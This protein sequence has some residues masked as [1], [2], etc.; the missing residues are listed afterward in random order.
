MIEVIGIEGSHE[1]KVAYA[2]KAAFVAQWPGLE[3]SPASEEHVKIAANAKLAGYQ[4]SDVDIVI[5]AVFHRARHFVVRRPIKDKE[6]RSVSGVKVRVQNL[7]CAIEVKAQ[8]GD[9]VSISGDEVNVRYK[10]KWKSATDQNVK[11]VHAL[12]N[13]FEDQY[14]DCWVYRCVYL[15]GIDSLPRVNGLARPEAGAVAS[16]AP[17]GEL[18]AAISGVNGLG[19]WGAEYVV[20]SA[21]NE[22]LKKVLEAPV[23][24][25][26][27][28]SRLDRIR[29]DR[30]SS[31]RKEAERLAALLGKQRVHIRGH[32]GT[33]KTMLMLQAAHLA[34]ELH[35]RRCLVLTYNHALAGDIKR[36]LTLLAVPSSDEG[37]GIE[38]KTAMSFVSTWLARLGLGTERGA[39]FDEYEK[40]CNECIGLLEGG[41]I[42]PADVHKTID[43]DPDALRFDAIIVDEAQDWPQPEAA[44]LTSLYGGNRV[45]V[46]DGREQ[47]LR[48]KA[49]DW[50]R[51]LPAGEVGE[52]RSLSRCLRMKRNLGI[53]ANTVAR[54]AGLNWEIEP[55]DEAAG[56]RVIILSGGYAS[57]EALVSRLL[58]EARE[59]GNEEVDFL[60]CVPPSDVVEDHSGRSSKL[61]RALSEQGHSTW[62]AANDLIR[63]DFPRSPNVLRVLQY[64]SSRGLEGWTTVLEHFDDAWEYKRRD[65]LARRTES[66]SRLVPNAERSARLAAWHWCMI[67]LTRPIDTLVITLR[68]DTSLA[69][70]VMRT[71][72]K[73]NP[74]F[75]E[76]VGE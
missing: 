27:V 1:Y 54:L 22:V 18:L 67:A 11:Q 29:M 43:H 14:L 60:H 57:H 36:L 26:V 48:G 69:S 40:V 17:A 25:Q 73:E 13:Y 66:S 76:V 6:G 55:N 10:G 70:Q 64:E 3:Q 19:K 50:S 7:V 23:F 47:L 35:G 16:S 71:A 21:K 41:A 46:A 5:G 74:D 9:S 58:E 52:E 30:V 61:A 68:S 65:W 44:L 37:G 63:R 4:V 33:G 2:I 45:S 28:P 24:R 56:G 42:S 38:V 59:A 31:R 49:T 62:D 34:Y 12:K 75:A 32:G 20:S 39:A 51:T 53:F 15:D 72:A 8:D